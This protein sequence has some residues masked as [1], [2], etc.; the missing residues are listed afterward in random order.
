LRVTTAEGPVPE[1]TVNLDR[2]I[3]GPAQIST[4]KVEPLLPPAPYGWMGEWTASR[5]RPTPMT[6]VARKACLQLSSQAT[7]TVYGRAPVPLLH[8]LD[9]AWGPL[10]TGTRS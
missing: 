3:A 1:G 9:L 7:V 8:R 10:L 6:F 5:V 2:E 4:S